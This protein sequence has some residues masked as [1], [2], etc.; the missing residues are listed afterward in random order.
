MQLVF[1]LRGT[2]RII[3][4]DTGLNITRA[5][6]DLIQYELKVVSTLNIKFSAIEFKHHEGIGAVERVI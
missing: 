3:W 6:K 2:P 1:A 4:I 5:G